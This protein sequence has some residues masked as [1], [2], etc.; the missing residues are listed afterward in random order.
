MDQQW[1]R[2]RL[3][4]VD[5]KQDLRRSRECASDLKFG[6]AIVQVV[7][8]RPVP[9]GWGETETEKHTFFNL[10]SF[11]AL[12]FLDLLHVDAALCQHSAIPGSSSRVQKRQAAGRIHSRTSDAQLVVILRLPV[13]VD[14]IRPV[15]CNSPLVTLGFRKRQG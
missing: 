13:V 3:G 10:T 9:S 15:E 7:S 8:N 14:N 1:L 5:D 2:A 12:S 6:R 4:V 11:P